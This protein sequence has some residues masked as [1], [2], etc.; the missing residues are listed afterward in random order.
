M[1]DYAASVI[2]KVSRANIFN[3]IFFLMDISH[4]KRSEVKYVRCLLEPQVSRDIP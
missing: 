4:N 3:D 2:I 1:K